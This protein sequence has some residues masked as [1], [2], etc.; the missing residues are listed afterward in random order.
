MPLNRSGA[1]IQKPKSVVYDS[2]IIEFSFSNY[3]LLTD[4]IP[5]PDGNYKN[6]PAVDFYQL[7]YFTFT[8]F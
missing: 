3:E 8:Y 2:L 1:A 5:K 6:M 4:E 7:I